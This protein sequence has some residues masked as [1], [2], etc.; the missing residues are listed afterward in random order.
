[1]VKLGEFTDVIGID[2]CRSLIDSLSGAPNPEGLSYKHCRVQDMV[3]VFGADSVD[4]V[5]DKAC[6]D[7]ILVRTLCQLAFSAVDC[8]SLCPAPE[9]RYTDY[10]YC[11]SAARIPPEKLTS[12]SKQ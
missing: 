3:E 4:Y 1:M 9:V 10:L 7:A 2:Q 6:L 11:V 8:R 5:V 12:I